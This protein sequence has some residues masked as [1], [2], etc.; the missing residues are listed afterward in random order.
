M[1]NTRDSVALVTNVVVQSFELFYE[2]KDATDDK[3]IN[4]IEWI[5]ILRESSDVFDAIKDLKSVDLSEI[6]EGGLLE[7]SHLIMNSIEKELKITVNDVF[8]ILV[9]IR[10]VYRLTT[11]DRS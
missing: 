11:E 6:N 9:I 2:V 1:E 3:K 8:N 7:L 10:S 5:R 4:W